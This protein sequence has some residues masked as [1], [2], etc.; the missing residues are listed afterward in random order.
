MIPA[1]EKHLKRKISVSDLNWHQFFMGWKE[2]LTTVIELNSHLASIYSPH[3]EITDT[4]L[5]AWRR[6]LKSVGCTNIT[7]YK[8]NISNVRILIC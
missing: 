5:G 2:Q 1:F 6:M 8:K 3:F 4:I 7:P